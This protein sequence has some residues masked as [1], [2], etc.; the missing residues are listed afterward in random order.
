MEIG[1][2][3]EIFM[4]EMKDS[5]IEWIG[6]I[7]KDWNLS[8]I[9]AMY[10]ERSTKVSDKIFNQNTLAE[11]TRQ[12]QQMQEIQKHHEDQQKNIMDMRKAISDYC[13]AARKVSPDYQQEAINQCLQEI[14]IQA[15]MDGYKNGWR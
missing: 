9:G 7:P 6:E 8:K 4:R 3:G 13:N 15:S 14:M 11:Y 10:D 5:G 12:Q 1:I 2:D